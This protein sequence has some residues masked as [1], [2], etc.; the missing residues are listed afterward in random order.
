MSESRFDAAV[1]ALMDY[2]AR[3][4]QTKTT[5]GA[6]RELAMLGLVLAEQERTGKPAPGFPMYGPQDA[7]RA[8]RD[9]VRLAELG[10]GG[11]C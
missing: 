2:G 9:A 5:A 3:P 4:E 10:D 1:I 7:E 11:D 6:F 8:L